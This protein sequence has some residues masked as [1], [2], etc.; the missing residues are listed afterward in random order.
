MS[1][2]PVLAPRAPSPALPGDPV[3]DARYAVANP[4]VLHTPQQMRDIMAGLL[5]MIDGSRCKSP[6]CDC[7]AD[8]A[9]GS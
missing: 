5:R 4:D 8:C 7:G 9:V 6:N 3:A 2:I 1:N